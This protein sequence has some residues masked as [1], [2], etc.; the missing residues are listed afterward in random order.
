MSQLYL[1]FSTFFQGVIKNRT[2]LT[3]YDAIC[4]L[5]YGQLRD[6][7]S[8][9]ITDRTSSYYATGTT[10]I[11]KKCITTL[12]DQP[13]S[14]IGDRFK[15]LQLHNLDNSVEACKELIEKV[16]GL[17]KNDENKLIHIYSSIISNSEETSYNFL[18]A[19]FLQALRCNPKHITRLNKEDQS[20]LAGLP[21]GTF[22][23]PSPPS[24]HGSVFDNITVNSSTYSPLDSLYSCFHKAN[25]HVKCFLYPE[26][27]PAYKAFCNSIVEAE[28]DIIGLD[29]HDLEVLLDGLRHHDYYYAAL[30]AGN[31]D[32]INYQCSLLNLQR[33]KTIIVYIIANHNMSLDEV[34]RI[35]EGVQAQA[36]P[37]CNLIFALKGI[38]ISEIECILLWS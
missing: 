37:E 9:P 1:N 22:V 30:M 36:P 4:M 19:A 25:M 20:F 7:C 35:V 3:Q 31:L 16:V 34:E 5:L 27:L 24:N 8:V 18:I 32:T 29:I 17:S 26:D 12:L 13:Q 28:D 15:R 14:D 6:E 33:A 11:S 21:S 2:N 23:P 10:N 38:D